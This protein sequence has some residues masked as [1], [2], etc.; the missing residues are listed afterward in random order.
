MEAVLQRTRRP[1]L[2]GLDP[3]CVVPW[4]GQSGTATVET[5]TVPLSNFYQRTTVTGVLATAAAQ[6]TIRPDAE[7]LFVA[8]AGWTK[9]QPDGQMHIAE[10]EKLILAFLD[11]CKVF[12]GE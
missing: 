2:I 6:Q 11:L 3:G 1:W 9:K 12:L 7:L 10:A 5:I 8:G 4:Q